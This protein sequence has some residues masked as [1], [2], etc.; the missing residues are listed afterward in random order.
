MPVYIYRIQ[1]TRLEML[2]SGPTDREAAVVAQHFEYLKGLTTAGQVLM[3]GR[4]LTTD[5]RTF[6]VVVFT[7]GSEAAAGEV[8]AGDPAVRHG[9]MRAELLPFRVA[10]WSEKGPPDESVGA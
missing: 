4:T 9:V 2:S 7:A 1:P 3:A 10:L 5:E 6:G 8:V